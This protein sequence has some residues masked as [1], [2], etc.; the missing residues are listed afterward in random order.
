MNPDN[1]KIIFGG[2][3]LPEN[4]LLNDAWTFN[5]SNLAFNSTLP[6]IPGAVCTL[7]KTK[8]DFSFFSISHFLKGDIPSARKGHC[9]ITHNKNLYIFGGKSAN[10]NEQMFQIYALNLG[11]C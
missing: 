2:L 9:A 3:C 6:E 1:E 11:F 8:V 5:Y 4:N 10:P 7:R